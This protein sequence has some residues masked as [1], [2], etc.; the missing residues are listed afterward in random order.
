MRLERLSGTELREAARKQ[1]IRDLSEVDLAV[2]E[3][4]GS[5]S[6]FRRSSDRPE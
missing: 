3:N 5:V 6:F 4:D 2:L 1:G